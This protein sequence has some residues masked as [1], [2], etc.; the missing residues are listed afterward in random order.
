MTT[1]RPSHDARF[2]AVGLAALTVL[3][4]LLIGCSP[5]APGDSRE[6]VGA[7]DN[8]A[9]S[10]DAVSGGVPIGTEMVA[11]A[12]L[13]FRTGPSTNNAVL[14][15]LPNGT[16]VVTV[17]QT[18]PQ[19]GFYKIKQNGTTGWAYGAYLEIVGSGDG[20]GTTGSMPLGTQL[21]TTTALNLRSQ[22]SKT[23]MVITVMP[24][25]AAVTVVDQ[26]DA[27]NGYYRVQ[28]QG[29][30]G[31]AAGAYL[32][33][34]SGSSQTQPS[35]PSQPSTTGSRADAI[36]RAKA[37]TG[38]SYWWGHGRWL[39]GGP[40]SSNKGSCSGSCPS[41]SHSGQYGA[42]C[43]GYVAKIW[44]VPSSNSDITQ[45]GHPY[46]TD[47]FANTSAYWSSISRGSL[48]AAD[49]LVY[50]SGSSG[51]IV[52]YGAGDGWGSMSVYECKGCAAGC[53]YDVRTL[54]TAY[55]AIRRAGY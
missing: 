52:L 38:F 7:E 21:V 37:G 20:S 46:S 36:A 54:G 18:T 9:Y 2:L 8:V 23:S 14:R 35:Q 11:T 50:H 41:C 16:H 43:S 40:T 31:W 33:P 10:D 34:G 51:H 17:D 42:D 13:N 49:A 28:Y 1:A 32:E 45:D 15:V 27:N 25:G 4:S 30:K 19:N 5:A 12:D 24:T 53:V 26:Q 39:P 29:T 3:L 47:S 55:K 22:P 44:Q 6:V 48:A